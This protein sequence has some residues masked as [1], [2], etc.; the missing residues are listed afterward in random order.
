MTPLSAIRI[1]IKISLLIILF[2]Y[3]RKEPFNTSFAF[4]NVIGIQA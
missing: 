4:M 2:L 3:L 1:V